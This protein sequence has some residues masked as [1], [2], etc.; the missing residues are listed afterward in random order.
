[1]KFNFRDETGK[2]VKMS[3]KQVLNTKAAPLSYAY[4]ETSDPLTLALAI[5][6]TPAVATMKKAR[7]PPKWLARPKARSC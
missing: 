2:A 7:R 1:V 3:S 5:I 4:E 6:H